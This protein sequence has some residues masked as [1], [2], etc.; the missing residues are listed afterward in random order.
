[1]HWYQDEEEEEDDLMFSPALL[2]RR[3]SESWIDSAPIEVDAS[4][5]SQQVNLSKR[6]LISDLSLVLE[7]PDQRHPSAQEI[8]AGCATNS[9]EQHDEPRGGVG[10]RLSATRGSETSEGRVRAIQ[11]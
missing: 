4:S 3:A 7:H 8:A 6:E 2:A 1:M 5:P 9:G 10:A 11:S